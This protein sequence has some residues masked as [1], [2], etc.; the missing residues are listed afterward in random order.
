MTKVTSAPKLHTTS[1]SVLGVLYN[2][3]LKQA[4][5]LGNDELIQAK[6]AEIIKKYRNPALDYLKRSRGLDLEA[7]EYL[8][9]LLAFYEQRYDEALE[10]TRSV[11]TRLPWMYEAYA[12]EGEI[13]RTMGY[14]QTTNGRYDA[15]HRDYRSAENSY[16][17]AMQIGQSDSAMYEGLAEINLAR[18]ETELYGKGKDIPGYLNQ[19]LDSASKALQADPESGNAWSMLARAY[20][21]KGEYQRD[22]G[23]DPRSALQKSI[24]AA[25]QAVQLS[26]DLSGYH[27]LLE[28]NRMLATYVNDRGLDPTE[29]VNNAQNAYVHALKLE[30]N[31]PDTYNVMGLCYRELGGYQNRTGKD[32]RAALQKAIDAYQKSIDCDPKSPYP[33]N[34]MGNTYAEIAQYELEQNMDPGENIRRR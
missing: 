14:E 29:S 25:E 8:E 19:A 18:I 32:P 21:R 9:A 3:E 11:Y 17:A 2:K 28:A 30:P 22:N 1:A 33:Y 20:S 12:L 7:P 26:P 24:D 13:Y 34:N 23:E 16:R 6:K 31:H 27:R 10:K 15:A 5:R 4:L